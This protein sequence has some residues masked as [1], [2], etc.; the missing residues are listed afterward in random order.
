VAEGVGTALLL[1]TVVGSGIMGERLAGGNVAVALLAN[2]LATGAALVALILTF[3]PI[4]G[5]QFNPVVTLVVA[6]E[7]GLPWRDVPS[8]VAAQVGGALVGVA[9][10]DLMFDLARSRARDSRRH[11]ASGARAG[12]CSR[13][14]ATPDARARA[15]RAISPAESPMDIAQLDKTFGHG[16]Q[17]TITAGKGGLACIRIAN[18]SAD[19]EIYVQGAHV[20]AFQ[21]K[22]Q[23]PVVWTSAAS[24]FQPGKAIRGGIPICWPWFGPHPTN[25]S[26]PAH[27]FARSAPWELVGVEPAASATRITL[28]LTSP[29]PIPEQFPAPFSL[30]YTIEV[31]ARLTLTL[32]YVNASHEAQVVTEA[33]HTYL[34]VSDVRAVTIAGLAGVAYDDKVTRGHATEGTAPIRLG[35][36]TDRVYLD[37]ATPVTVT[38]PGLRRALRIS[39]TGSRSTVVW[40]P[41]VEKAKSMAD[42]GDDEWP[43]ML[44]IEAANAHADRV[45]VAAGATH[46]IAT[47]IEVLPA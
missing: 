2:A 19:A 22:G 11:P 23:A 26:F 20:T 21:P 39:K 31:G 41:W 44:C 8:Y 25:A 17:I 18:A 30:T 7:R 4:S 37:T 36:E 1:A 47:E 6:W 3:G 38:D 24:L 9:V 34:A 32:T 42:F 28:R 40:N 43:A 16:D 10:A 46:T 5:A 14:G 13:L 45:T 15:Q 33:L 35:G 27:G 29:A 12:T